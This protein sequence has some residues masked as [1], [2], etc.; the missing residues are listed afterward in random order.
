MKVLVRHKLRKTRSG[1]YAERDEFIQAPIIRFGRGADCEIHMP[2]PRVTLHYAELTEQTHGAV[3]ECA[4]GTEIRVNGISQTTASLN[5]GDKVSLGPY[6]LV[7]LDPVEAAEKAEDPGEKASIESVDIAFT[8]ELSRPLGN[9]LSALKD[10]SST[11]LTHAG[12][13]VRGWAWLMVLAVL[14]VAVAAPLSAYFNKAPID[15]REILSGE[16]RPLL[17]SADQLWKSGPHSGA[18]GFFGDKCEACHRDAFVQVQNDACIDCHQNTRQ[19]ADPV[20]F[21]TASLD[22]HQCQTCHKE[23]REDPVPLTSTHDSQCRECHTKIAAKFEKGHPFGDYPYDR[24]TRIQFNHVSHM[25]KYFKD[26]TNVD[27]APEAC[28]SCHEPDSQGKFMV[29]GGFEQNCASCHGEFI[30]DKTVDLIVLPGIDLSLLADHEDEEIV[31]RGWRAGEWPSWADAEDL[32]PVMKVLLSSDEEFTAAWTFL[33]EEESDLFGMDLV[34]LE[35]LEA[36]EDVVRGIKRLVHGALTEGQDHLLERLQSAAGDASLDPVAQQYLLGALPI[37]ML[38]EAQTRWFPNLFEEMEAIAEEEA[39]EM[40]EEMPGDYEGPDMMDAV[41]WAENGGWFIEGYAVRYKPKGHGDELIKAWLD[42]AAK[43]ITNS[44][45]MAPLSENFI[46]PKGPGTCVACHSVDQADSGDAIINWH[47][48]R[49]SSREVH[50]TEFVHE[51][52]FTLVG[53]E[54]C[55]NCHA[56]DSEAKYAESFADWN[57][58]TFDSNF[59]PVESS[60]CA[61]CHH[62]TKVVTPCTDCHNFHVEPSIAGDRKNEISMK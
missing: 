54:G 37:D 17:A 56:I 6:D 19:H 61:Q 13:S 12:L 30:A 31:E 27:K 3:I 52:H 51:R 28:G 7:V 8:L 16:D 22:V 38:Q 58:S 41:D 48:R 25:E 23:H 50:K 43:T 40:P 49:T 34:T 53:D 55:D 33:K 11:D 35:E 62:S 10:R 29:I 5:A 18:H 32:P 45:A 9:D 44:E 57:P 4:S 14:I 15:K 36:A 60:T 26:P 20:E 24:R 42:T 21:P 47:S 39:P 46:T 59:A 1:G 2:D